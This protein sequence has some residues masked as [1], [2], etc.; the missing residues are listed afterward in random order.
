MITTTQI[1]DIIAMEIKMHI[2]Q[3]EVFE[4]LQKR[5]YEIKGFPIHYEATE[6]MLISERAWT[7]HT[8]TAT[9]DGEEQ[10]EDNQFLKVF[11]MEMKTLL[12]QI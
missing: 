10:S 1:N 2:P 4:F 7:W 3:T 12:K 9:K 5:G 11:E 8:F 6:E